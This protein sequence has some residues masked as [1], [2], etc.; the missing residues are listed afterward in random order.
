MRL[1]RGRGNWAEQ[2]VV[3]ECVC[4]FNLLNEVSWY[5]QLSD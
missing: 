3:A 5:F 1:G 2:S 4:V